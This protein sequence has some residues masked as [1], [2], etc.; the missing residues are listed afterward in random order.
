MEIIQD[1]QL[2]RSDFY[3]ER[4]L[5]AINLRC[6]VVPV[7]CLVCILEQLKSV[8]LLGQPDP[9]SHD[10]V[11]R[12]RIPKPGTVV[13]VGGFEEHRLVHCIQDAI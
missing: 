1:P 12:H 8:V 4:E 2:N 5:H 7:S 13:L 10:V 9:L 11:A 6:Q 3:L